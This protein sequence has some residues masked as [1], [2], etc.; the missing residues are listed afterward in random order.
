MNIFF[1]LTAQ[2]FLDQL[3][4]P[5]KEALRTAF[6]RLQNANAL[7]DTYEDFE[8]IKIPNERGEP[9]YYLRATPD[10]RILVEERH[11]KIYIIDIVR[12]SQIDALRSGRRA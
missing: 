1:D 5:D 6:G 8:P 11:N 4:P 10:L 2:M 9:L 12:Q 3:S 7:K